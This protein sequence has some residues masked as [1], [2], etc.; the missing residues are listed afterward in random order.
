MIPKEWANAVAAHHHVSKTLALRIARPGTTTTN[1]PKF[2]AERTANELLAMLL[3]SGVSGNHAKAYLVDVLRWHLGYENAPSPTGDLSYLE[4]DFIRR[5]A[6][7]LIDRHRDGLPAIE[8]D[9]QAT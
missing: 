1:G 5:R 7:E 3:E 9:R 6:F 2:M 8:R 4:L